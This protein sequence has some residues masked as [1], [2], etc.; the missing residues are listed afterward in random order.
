[1]TFSLGS[2]SVTRQ[3]PNNE[4][5]RSFVGS[6]ARQRPVNN[7]GVVFSLGL[8]HGSQWG[9]TPRITMLANASSKLLL[10]SLGL[11]MR[12]GSIVLLIQPELQKGEVVK[13]RHA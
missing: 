3:R 10:A 9:S 4:V 7:N 13:S 2:G 11:V 5:M 12:A 8:V 6:V 1:L